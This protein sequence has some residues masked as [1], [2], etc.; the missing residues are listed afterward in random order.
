MVLG[1]SVLFIQL[2]FK[3][4]AFDSAHLNYDDATYGAA[5]KIAYDAIKADFSNTLAM[6]AI[7]VLPLAIQAENW[8]WSMYMN[9]DAESALRKISQHNEDVQSMLKETEELNRKLQT[10]VVIHE[11]ESEEDEPDTKKDD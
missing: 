9:Q 4:L 6:T 11:E 3:L 7:T 5:A 2:I 8:K 10:K 1:G